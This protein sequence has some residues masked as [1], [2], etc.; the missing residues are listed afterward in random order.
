MNVFE[1]DTISVKS[2]KQAAEH[3]VRRYG[4]FGW[5]LTEKEEDSLYEDVTHM[6]FTRPHFIKNRDELQLLQVRLEIAYNNMGKLSSK[7]RLRTS[8]F[9]SLFALLCAALI[10]GGI[11]VI[12]L[13]DGLLP[14]ISGAL[15]CAAGVAAG[16]LGGL[17]SH[18][19][20][21]KDRQKYGLLIQ[22]QLDTIDELC[23]KARELRGE[24]E[25]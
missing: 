5:T 7:S 13:L 14:I 25:K 11:A 4:D 18:R 9:S 16:V 22:G 2:K 10:A 12:L 20:Y 1:E 21:K 24:D 3:I 19:V 17:V 6:T 8:L 15:L 23:K